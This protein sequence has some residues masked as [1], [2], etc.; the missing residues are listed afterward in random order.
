MYSVTDRLLQLLAWRPN[1]PPLADRAL[2]VMR[3]RFGPCPVCGEALQGHAVVKLASV[4]VNGETDRELELE[5]LVSLRQWEQAT[6]YQDWDSDRRARE[7]HL[8][9]CPKKAGIALMR[10]LTTPEMWADDVVEASEVLREQDHG[11]VLR[12]AGDKWLAL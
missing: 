2:A 11:T 8:I 10:L 4:F 3:D 6:A 1:R 7:Y 9:R 12:V 5:R